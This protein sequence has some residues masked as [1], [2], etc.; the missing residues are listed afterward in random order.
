[1]NYRPLTEGDRDQ[2][3]ALWQT[4][5]DDPPA[6]VD[7]FF[8]NRYRPE[9]SAGAFDGDRLVSVIH[10]WPMDLSLG[11]ASFSALMT[12]GVATLP[13]EW[14]KGYMH[15]TMTFLR[16][17]ARERGVCALFNHPQ[18]PGAYARL[19]FRPSTCTRYWQGDETFSAGKIVPFSEEEAFSI[20]RRIAEKYDGFVL[21]DRDAFHL[22]MEDYRADGAKGFMLEQGGQAI[23]YAVCFDK[24]DVFGEEV[25]SLG[26][27]GPLLHE[28]SRL[29]NGREVGAK[30]P[31]DVEAAGEMRVQNVMLADEDIWA[32]LETSGAPRFCVDEY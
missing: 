18:R 6:F 23:G 8:E 11:G 31:P 20:Y 16:D 22:K 3:K 4:C 19:G 1:M 7:W 26:A 12:S 13:R 2:A 24:A 27:Y 29:A 15:R 32:A 9:W 28:L 5:F 10:G 21:R 14:G 30:L 25:L 17:Q